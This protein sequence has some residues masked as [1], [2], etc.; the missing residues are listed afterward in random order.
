MFRFDHVLVAV[1]FAALIGFGVG[2]LNCV[3]FIY[4]QT[5]QRF[6]GII[7]R[8]MFLISGIFFLYEDMPRLV[9]EILWW[10]PLIHLTSIMRSGFYPGYEPEFV[11]LVYVA[12]CALTPLTIG[13]VLL[14]ILGKKI[15]EAA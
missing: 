1:A 6:F 5:W 14:H 8:P 10:N 2:S 9:R 13:F 3:L 11:S 4:F 15:L 7:N 12:V